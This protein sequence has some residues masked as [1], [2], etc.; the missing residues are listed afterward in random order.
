MKKLTGT[1]VKDGKE[2]VNE[3]TFDLKGLTVKVGKGKEKV[4]K[5]KS[6]LFRTLYDNGVDISVIS[7]EC[8]SH[9]SFVYGVI[10]SS[11]EVRKT[12]KESKSDVFRKMFDEGKKVGE[13]AKETNS[14]Y[15]YVFGVIKKYKES[16]GTIDT[17]SV[18]EEQKVEEQV[19]Q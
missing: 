5:S 2:V 17:E 16:K 11:R 15:S 13:I 8:D 12:E 4:V 9:Y 6:D 7:K 18:K 1:L 14:N 10:S 3:I 19:A